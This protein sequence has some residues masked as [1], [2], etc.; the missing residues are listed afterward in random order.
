MPRLSPNSAFYRSVKS[1]DSTADRYITFGSH[2]TYL[3]NTAGGMSVWAKRGAWRT[4][5]ENIMELYGT[6]GYVR[7]S[8]TGRAITATAFAN[9]STIVS[10]TYNFTG[11]AMETWHNIVVTWD[12]TSLDVYLDKTRVINSTGDKRMSF[13]ANP[14]FYVGAGNAAGS[15]FFFDGYHTRAALYNAKLSQS[16]V[17]Q[18][19]DTISPSSEVSAWDYTDKSGSTIT[20]T[21]GSGNNGTIVSGAINLDVPILPRAKVR[22][23]PSAIKFTTGKIESASNCGIS[24]SGAWTMGGWVFLNAANGGGS[25]DFPFAM[26]GATSPYVGIDNGFFSIGITAGISTSTVSAKPY[27]GKAFHLAGSYSGGTGTYRIYINGRQVYQATVGSPPSVTAAKFAVNNYANTGLYAL[28][29]AFAEVFCATSE[30]TETEI[31][32][33]AFGIS[34]PTLAIDWR[35][36]ENTGTTATDSS[37]NGNNGTITSGTWTTSLAPFSSRSQVAT[38]QNY[39]VRSE[40][41]DNAS[42]TKSG[43]SVLADQVAAPDGTTT[44]EKVTESS[45]NENHFVYQTTANVLLIS[46]CTLSVY[47]KLGTRRYITLQVADNSGYQATFDLQSGA[48]TYESGALGVIESIGNGWY[49]C[50]ITFISVGGTQVARIWMNNSSGALGNY[51]GDGSYVYLWGAQ[52]VRADWSGQYTV[53]TSS[54][55]TSA[56]QSRPPYAQNILTYS[57]DLSNAAWT[58]T[59]STASF[60]QTAYD[61]VACSELRFSAGAK[62]HKAGLSPGQS[63]DNI[64]TLS[65][66]AKKAT[67]SRDWIL[68][69]TNNGNNGSWFDIN[70][71]VLGTSA[72]ILGAGIVSLG[73][74]YYRC[75]ITY[76]KTGTVNDLTEVWIANG[77]G[78]SVYAGNTSYSVILDRLMVNEGVKPGP[79]V[80]TSGSAVNLGAPRHQILYN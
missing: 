1:T 29:G 72:N 30:L 26:L 69:T 60:N 14:T 54:T 19:W 2:A 31:Y 21:R 59:G 67:T 38:S 27:V 66:I 20:L 8:M 61:G 51:L 55:S 74:G 13:S 34:R 63:N 49:R 22:N 70:N 35:L 57:N 52:L 4:D 15:G 56:I 40:G 25:Y 43:C 79:L 47:A 28:R 3:L 80:V 78:G 23:I 17:N 41:L 46:K 9:S 39:L 73:N 5:G 37:G 24:G 77:D 76:N 7:V 58:K 42:W 10:S 50:S 6:G 48:V 32:N 68:L 44:A 65:V 71:G 11:G 45:I 36:D 33:L 62:A 53:T 18:I 16:D 75:W 12:S 64:Y